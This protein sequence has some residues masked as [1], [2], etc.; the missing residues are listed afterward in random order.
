MNMRGDPGIN[1]AGLLELGMGGLFEI[2]CQR[3]DIFLLF[4][5]RIAS[6]S[7]GASS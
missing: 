5:R 1:C 3:C 4:G 7:V 6:V 2:R